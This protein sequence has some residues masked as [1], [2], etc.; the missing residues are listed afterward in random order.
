MSQR[1]KRR[2]DWKTLGA[3]IVAALSVIR[4]L[5]EHHNK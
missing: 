3:V 4:V 2:F 1:R 5:I